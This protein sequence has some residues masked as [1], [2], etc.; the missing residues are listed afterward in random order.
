MTVRL[1]L[2]AV[3]IND[4]DLATRVRIA[5]TAHDR[6][7]TCWGNDLELDG[8]HARSGFRAFHFHNR[9]LAQ[10]LFNDSLARVV[11]IA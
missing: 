7:A 10:G 11:L 6:S 4:A 5:D 8:G 9:L 1:E 3:F 2:I